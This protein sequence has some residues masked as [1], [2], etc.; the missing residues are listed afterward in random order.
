MI[1]FDMVVFIVQFKTPMKIVNRTDFL[2][3][4]VTKKSLAGFF[5]RLSET[6]TG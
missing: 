5:R 1:G 4:S 2:Q 3:M 6:V